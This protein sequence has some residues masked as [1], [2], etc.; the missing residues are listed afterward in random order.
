MSLPDLAVRRPIT[1]FMAAIAV[2]TFGFLTAQRLPVNL[3]PDLAYPTLTIQTEYPDA[4]PTSVEQFVTR[5]IEEG[6]GVI[7]GLR[8]MRSISRAGISEVI[9]EF[10]WNEEM[11]FTALDV[12]EKI[13]LVVLPREAE[14][15]RVLRFDPS[16]DPIMRLSLSGD[17]SLDDLR[18][19]ADRWLKPKL[20]AIR[21]VAAVKV[22][23]GL[24]PEIEVEADEDRIGAL[25]L[26]L[27]DLA[28]ALQSEN[29]NL[30]GGVLKDFH[31]VYLVRTLHEFTDLDQLRRTVVRDTPQGRVRV[32]DVATVTRGHKDREEI[33]RSAGR[34]VV[35]LAIHREGSANTVAAAGAVREELLSLRE[36]MA[37]DLELKILSDQS[38][39]ISEAVGQVWSAALIGGILAVL[40]L[41]FFLRDLS[42]TLIIALSIPVSVV[43]TF[44]PLY[45]LD[46][47]LNIMSLGGLALGVGM[48]VDNSIV[49]L[50]AIDRR[51]REGRGRREAAVLGAREVAAAVAASTF[52]TV[53][54]F[55]PIVFV[56][57]IAGQLFYDQAVTVCCSLLA[58]L[59]VSLTLIPALAALELKHWIPQSFETLFRFDQGTGGG[60]RLPMTMGAA[61]FILAP[62]GNGRHWLSR[63][64]T[65]LFLPVRL[66]ILVLFLILTLSW[67]AFS[68]LF[69]VATSPVAWLFDWL[70]RAYPAGLSRALRHR[71]T[72]LILA[73]SLCAISVAAMPLL[74]TNLVPDLS[75][76]QFAFRL[77]LPEGTP[78]E[79]TAQMV[80]RIEAPL[81]D[82]PRFDRIF[83]VVGS[84]P[85]SASG[86]RTL[87]E[88]LAQID[89]VMAAGTGAEEEAG[90]VERVREVL[91]QFPDSE[92]ELFRPSVLSIRPPVEIEIFSEDLAILD[93]ASIVVEEVLQRIPGLVDVGT[94]REPG[95]PEVRVILDRER[96]A[97]LGLSAADLANSLRRKVRGDLV[98][99]FREGEQRLDIRLRVSQES[100]DR[101]SGIENLRIR[102][103]NNTV[104]PISAVARVEVGYGPASIHRTGGARV[105]EV[106]GKVSGRDL[107]DTLRRVR[108]KIAGIS[109]PGRARIEMSGQEQELKVSFDSLKMAMALA[110]FLV[111]AVMA[112]Q[113]ESLIFPF[114]ILG[115]VPLGIIGIVVALF[116][117]RNP[118]SVLVLIGAIMLAGIVVNNGIVLVD[119]VNR[120]RREGQ[121]L[122]EAILEAG[123][124]RLRPILMT[125][126]T[127]VLALLP[128]AVGL[129]AGDEL[130]APL[131]ITVIGGLS[132]ATIL[133]LIVTPCLYRVLSGSRTGAR[134]PEPTEEGIS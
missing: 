80:E 119:A 47:S 82:D 131:A 130:R 122:E 29:V 95:S 69:R 44:L 58:S 83:S 62:I 19:I 73:F 72:V 111:Y 54:V 90:A 15:P 4:A 38:G 51:R 56:K 22:R 14:P 20:E 134:E 37:D 67:T 40:I 94:T 71:W 78:L 89:F 55:F 11:D 75:Q 101:A 133:T 43:A 30:P 27:S 48:L 10:E 126:A 99:Q 49:V 39:Y 91:A 87:G 103:P 74:G 41:Y 12:R 31:A 104:V 107:G 33:T 50:E 25:G 70:V 92:P 81:L 117:T 7:P 79:T 1:I 110:I 35:E 102:L 76:G 17:R 23:G 106:T 13:G 129:G 45:E 26:T 97:S 100:R 28:Q 66:L 112:M 64:L 16:L 2:A 34:E 120:R 98:G 68:H 3:L 84:L 8:K 109:L 57:G 36:A 123:G 124:E 114:V 18:Q 105:A 108:E 61:G 6:V 96:T 46:V 127:T 86:R 52:T 65:V 116:L 85:S 113:F 24:D 5:P 77:R 125:T 128:M 88:N 53:S 32:E 118:I 115:S 121:R 63:V 42:S 21:G 132:L 59:V 93:Q 60:D 9:L